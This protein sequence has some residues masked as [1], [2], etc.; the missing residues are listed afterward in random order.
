MDKMN[1]IREAIERIEL[2]QSMCPTEKSERYGDL[3]RKRKKL[4]ALL[5]EKFETYEEE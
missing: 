3:E 4:M 5:Q 1:E 2:E